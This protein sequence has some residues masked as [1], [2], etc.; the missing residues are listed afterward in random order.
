MKNRDRATL[1]VWGCFWGAWHSHLHIADANANVAMETPQARKRPRPVVSCLR[2]RE[3]KL[4][5]DRILPCQNCIKSGCRS[6]CTFNQQPAES[7]LRSKRVQFPDAKDLDQN[8][9]H[10]TAPVTTGVGVIEDL[11]MRVVKLEEL[12][13]LRPQGAFGPIRDAP[14]QN[15]W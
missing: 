5:C 9:D 7:H 2:C 8:Q 10:P 1:T 6:D 3:K 15:S 4:K 12:L 13:A 14:V 11:Q